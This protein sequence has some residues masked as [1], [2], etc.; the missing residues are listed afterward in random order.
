M[1]RGI[2][3]IAQK[4]VDPFTFQKMNMKGGDF[5]KELLELIDADSLEKKFGGNR[6]NLTGAFFPP[7]FK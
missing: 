7:T 2:W 1:V 6:D 4:L 3:K 5:Q